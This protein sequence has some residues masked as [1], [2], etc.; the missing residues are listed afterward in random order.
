ME[1]VFILL[2]RSLR[3]IR[4]QQLQKVAEVAS[5]TAKHVLP[6]VMK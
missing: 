4:S 3:K 1:L 6:V 5:S 2:F